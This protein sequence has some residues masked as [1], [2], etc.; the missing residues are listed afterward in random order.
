MQTNETDSRVSSI[1]LLTLAFA[2][3]TW[4][5]PSSRPCIVLR[6]RSRNALYRAINELYRKR[7]AYVRVRSSPNLLMIVSTRPL[8]SYGGRFAAPL[9]K[10]SNSIR[11]RRMSSSKRLNCSSKLGVL[12]PAAYLFLIR[13]CSFTLT[14]LFSRNPQI[15]S[16][17][18]VV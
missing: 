16:P 13:I 14:S 15:V 18:R 9:K 7:C 3:D 2:A 4:S 11:N 8:V 6:H 12:S 17:R 1:P 10:M 5:R